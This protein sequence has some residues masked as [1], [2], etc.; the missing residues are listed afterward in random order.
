MAGRDF[1]LTYKE[2][3]EDDFSVFMDL[4]HADAGDYLEHA[5]KLMKMD[6]RK[7]E[8]LFRTVGEVRGIYVDGALA[9]FCWVEH[10][11]DVLHIHGL[12]LKNEYQDRGIGSEVLGMLE[13]RFAGVVDALELAV[14][15]SN[16][17]AK[18]LY[19]RL[20]FETVRRLDDEGFD[21][22]QKKIGAG[23]GKEQR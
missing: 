6:W 11:D 17:R 13:D 21:I 3:T 18:Q 2:A 23:V 16:V 20:G 12:I 19:E 15:D 7:F 1:N 22:M 14:H 8:H 4:I 9:G 10:R 5:M